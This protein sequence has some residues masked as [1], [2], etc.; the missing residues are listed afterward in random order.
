MFEMAS[1]WRC[2]KNWTYEK[3]VLPKFHILNPEMET[4]LLPSHSSTARF[5]CTRQGF[6]CSAKHFIHQELFWQLGVYVL[7]SSPRAC[8]WDKDVKKVLNRGWLWWDYISSTFRTASLLVEKGF[9]QYKCPHIPTFPPELF[10]WEFVTVLEFVCG[11]E[12]S[13]L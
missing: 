4:F 10:V 1:T 9:S 11:A 5:C 3:T 12:N 13:E 7:K 6:L 8:L 2:F